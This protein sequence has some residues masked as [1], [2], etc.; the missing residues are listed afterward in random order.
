MTIATLAEK[1]RDVVGSAS[2]I[3]YVKKDYVDVE[4][5]I[6]SI[7]KAE[8]VLNFHPQVDLMEGLRRTAA[9]YREQR[10][11]ESTEAQTAAS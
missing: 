7:A 9:W 2:E 1:V 3:V 10:A 11:V 5:R 6:P 4:L 8:E